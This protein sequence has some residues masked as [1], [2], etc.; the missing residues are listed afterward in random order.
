MFSLGATLFAAVQGQPPF[1]VTALFD[2]VVAVVQGEPVPFLH[3]G[4]LRAV[5][6][7]LLG[8]EPG[9]RP[10]AEQARLALVK[11]QRELHRHPA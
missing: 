8:K 9:D 3:A 7:P 4:P 11:V 6:E 1:R 10:T 2:T 5:L